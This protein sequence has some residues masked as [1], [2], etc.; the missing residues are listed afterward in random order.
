MVV[1]LHDRTGNLRVIHPATKILPIAV[2]PYIA[3]I[4]M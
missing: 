4:E 1:M 3:A 2:S